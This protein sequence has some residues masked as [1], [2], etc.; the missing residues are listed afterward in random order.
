MYD[1]GTHWKR[2]IITFLWKLEKIIPELRGVINKSENLLSNVFVSIYFHIYYYICMNDIIPLFPITTGWA[3][4]IQE[5]QL[6][7]PP[8]GYG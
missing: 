7:G 6:W 2:H 5:G 4:L 1:M 3:S 8:R